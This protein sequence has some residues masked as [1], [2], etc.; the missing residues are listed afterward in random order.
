MSK[1][2]KQRGHLRKFRRKFCV[3]LQLVA[4]QIHCRFLVHHLQVK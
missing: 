3:M 4:W 1:T 2:A